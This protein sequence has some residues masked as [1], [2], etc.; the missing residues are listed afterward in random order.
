M[1]DAEVRINLA[2]VAI[3]TS[4]LTLGISNADLAS[5]LWWIYALLSG[6]LTSMNLWFSYRRQAKKRRRR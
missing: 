4:Y 5:S 2:L 1:I 3:A 6:T